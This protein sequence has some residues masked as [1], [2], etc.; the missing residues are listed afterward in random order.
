MNARAGYDSTRGN[1][2]NDSK[3]D[4]PVSRVLDQALVLD[5]RFPLIPVPEG[6][7]ALFE[8]M[9]SDSSTQDY[10]LPL[11]GFA[12]FTRTKRIEENRSIREEVTVS[13]DPLVW[14]DPCLKGIDSG[15]R[16]LIQIDSWYWNP[17]KRGEGK[18]QFA[19]K[20]LYRKDGT[21]FVT[22]V[23]LSTDKT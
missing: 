11:L 8:D 19:F 7:Y 2:R 6:S 9:S 21:P 22:S 23:P 16:L 14:C 18:T 20:G 3:E 5:S 10:R 1:N 4:R 15:V 13:Y 17:E 12:G